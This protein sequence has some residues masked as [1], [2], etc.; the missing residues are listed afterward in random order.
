MQ[1]PAA[2]V[3]KKGKCPK[4]GIE[5]VVTEQQPQ[6]EETTPVSQTPP[7]ESS[8]LLRA[9]KKLDQLAAAKINPAEQ[10]QDS[11]ILFQH[12]D[13]TIT[14]NV[15]SFSQSVGEKSELVDN[16][17]SFEQYNASS[18]IRFW[19]GEDHG[20]YA[21]RFIKEGLLPQLKVRREF[22][23][24]VI[25]FLLWFLYAL[26]DVFIHEVFG[27][28]SAMRGFIPPIVTFIGLI[29]SIIWF[30]R[31]FK[32]PNTVDKAEPQGAKMFALYIEV[33]RGRNTVILKVF[34]SADKELVQRAAAVMT[35]SFG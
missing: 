2:L 15:I 26:T 10:V 9:A 22:L 31:R 6:A 23:F 7:E 16:V 17:T 12:E 20:A 32:E 3:G 8:I 28:E 21:R 14:R 35:E 19:A 24:L 30:I 25:L 18:I 13:V 34:R 27:G 29:G 33:P 4:C 1:L 5:C 11:N